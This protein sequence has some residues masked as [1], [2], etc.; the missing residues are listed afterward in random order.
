[1]GTKPLFGDDPVQPFNLIRFLIQ[2]FR[3]GHLRQHL[4]DPGPGENDVVGSKNF[5]GYG[6]FDGLFTVYDNFSME[7]N[8]FLSKIG[9]D[10]FSFPLYDNAV[11]KRKLAMKL[12]GHAFGQGF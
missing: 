5:S 6:V 12:D 1:M 9:K 7:F 2:N 10:V 4:G 11:Q 8:F 3:F